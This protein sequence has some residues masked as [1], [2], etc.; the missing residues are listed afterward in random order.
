M[1]VVASGD[2]VKVL[3]VILLGVL[4]HVFGSNIVVPRIMQRKVDIPPVLTIAIVLVMGALLGA[5]G[6][7][8]AVP[9]LCVTMVLIRH[10]LYREIYGE[11]GN[12]EAAVLR[13]TEPWTG[14]ERR[15]AAGSAK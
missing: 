4:V 9:V 2:W 12:A 15:Q 7:I 5:I 11:A 14:V 1:F 10:I 3:L 8:V 13:P 6:L